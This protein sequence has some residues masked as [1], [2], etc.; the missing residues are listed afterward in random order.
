MPKALQDHSGINVKKSFQIFIEV[1]GNPA[2][3][4]LPWVSSWA[5][6]NSAV[7]TLHWSSLNLV[8]HEPLFE[9]SRPSCI[10]SCLLQNSDNPN[11]QSQKSVK[12]KN[13]FSYPSK[14]QNW[15]LYNKWDHPSRQMLSPFVFNTITLIDNKNHWTRSGTWLNM[16]LCSEYE[17]DFWSA[18]LWL[19]VYYTQSWVRK[20]PKEY[21]KQLLKKHD[22]FDVVCS[23]QPNNLIKQ[24]L[25]ESVKFWN[26]W[27]PYW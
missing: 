16:I 26:Y 3:V 8:I 7:C 27:T 25:R 22:C 17:D 24:I 15:Q 6:L 13:K 18:V 21:R 12:T 14:N 10:V 11:W 5:V 19:A 23:T 9:I 1:L 4:I 2:L 20:T